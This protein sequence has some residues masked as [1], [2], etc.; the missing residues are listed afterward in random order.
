MATQVIKGECALCVNC[1][2][3]DYHV[4]DGRLIK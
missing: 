1:C 4:S 3:V 2:G